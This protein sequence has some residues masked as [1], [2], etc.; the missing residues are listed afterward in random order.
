MCLLFWKLTTLL[1]PTRF[2]EAL[3]AIEQ[4]LLSPVEPGCAEQKAKIQL[5]KPWVRM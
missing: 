5:P 4:R 1:M 2:Y 3:A